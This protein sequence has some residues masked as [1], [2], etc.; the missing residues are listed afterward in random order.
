MPPSDSAPDLKTSRTE[1][2]CWLILLALT[3]VNCVFQIA[4]FWRF[5]S[6]NINMDG[7]SY[8]GLARHLAD[9]NWKQS[10]HGYWS[11][12]AS[13]M[14]AAASM[15]DR[16]LFGRNFTLAGRVV[17]I[18]SFLLCLPLL[19]RLTFK[20]WHSRTA[21]VLA[22]FWFCAGRALIAI[23]VEGIFADFILTACVLL[24]FIF[25][26][27]AIRD[28]KSSAWIFMGAAHGLAFLAK[29]VAMPW[30]SISTVLALILRNARSPRRLASSF[31]LAF[32]FPAIVWASWGTILRTKY[33]V[34][35]TGYQLRANLMVNWARW[36]NH[37][38]L[39]DNLAFR[40]LPSVYDNY[41]VG[42]WPWSSISGFSLRNPALLKMIVATEIRT[43]PQAAKEGTIL[44]TPAGVLAFP[45]MLFLL[46]RRRDSYEDETRF[47]AIVL[48][49]ALSLIVAYCMLVFDERYLTPILPLLIAVGCPLVLPRKLVPDSPHIAPWLQKPALG[50]F[51]ASVVFFAV[52]WA[53][54]LR[55]ASRDYEVSCYQAA[56][57]LRNDKPSGTLVSLGEGPYPEHGAGFEV[58]TYAAYFAG[59]RVV[60]SNYALPPV[61]DAADL[62]GKALA[63]HADAVAVWG[64]PPDP[65]YVELL[66]GI[67]GA[68]DL[69]FVNAFFDPYKGEV[70][71]LFLFHH[72][73]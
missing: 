69:A 18:S 3:S 73:N 2:T 31:L 71:T 25:L 68:P 7:I 11:P 52:Y 6:Y 8:V 30:L 57:I 4:W 46:I 61:S 39:G 17:T 51:A 15:F 58:G 36:Q 42:E 35:T 13:W 14:I 10:L 72:R 48:L 5:H 49:S 59:W 32:L 29:A 41:M 21:A 23:A 45:L 40:E 44:L 16:N 63:V 66:R 22:V 34:F 26:L 38:L 65:R 12:L 70:G 64:S 33:G 55:T 27:N 20:L 1:R 54:P 37:R 9:G 28:N 67:R 56:A 24:Y 47:G 62:A 53:S 60:A 19:Y 43:L 50:L